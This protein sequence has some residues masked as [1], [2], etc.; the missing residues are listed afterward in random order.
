MDS[1]FGTDEDDFFDFRGRN[2]P[3]GVRVRAFEGNDTVFGSRFA[4]RLHGEQ[5]NDRL[6]GGGGNDELFGS[7]G[8]DRLFG[9]AGNDVIWATQNNPGFTDRVDPGAGRDIIYTREKGP[10]TV[11]VNEF[12]PSALDPDADHI[13]YLDSGGGKLDLDATSFE[14]D[15]HDAHGH[16]HLDRV[17]LEDIDSPF[18][19]VVNFADGFEPVF[20]HKPTGAELDNM[21]ANGWTA[22]WLV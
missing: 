2:D 6:F 19:L 20:D 3:D 21:H 7:E 8:H 15:R 18:K 16:W 5:G 9:G 14:L 10:G 17:V 1:F 22:T 12:H 13:V 4:D 11:V